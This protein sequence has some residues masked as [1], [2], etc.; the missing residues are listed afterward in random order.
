MSKNKLNRKRFL[1]PGAF[2]SAATA[3]LLTV[4]GCSLLPQEDQ[5]LKPPLVKPVEIQSRTAEATLGTIVKSLSGSAVL[6]PVTFA[7]HEFTE[8][9]GRIEEVLVRSG[10]EVK[11]GD[12]LIRLKTEGLDLE[13]IR[14]QVEVEKKRQEFDEAKR[15]R[16]PQALRVPA[17]ELKLAEEELK[18]VENQIDRLQLRAAMDGVVTFVDRIEPGDP[19]TA[20]RNAVTIADPHT[21]RLAFNSVPANRITEVQLGMEAM[22]TYKD[23]EF[24]GKVVQT[25]LSA[26]YTED[27]R[28]RELYSQTLY[29]EMDDP[30]EDMSMGNYVDVEILIAQRENVVI[31]P[32][33]GLRE[34]FGRVAV[35]VLDGESRREVDVEKGLETSTEVEIVK[36]LEAGQQIILK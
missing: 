23:Q 25:P 31:I 10:D 35:Q 21:M 4:S 29:I 9:G 26:P 17:L 20:F 11:E 1:R 18:V 5:P 34:Y 15:E 28:L 27:A 33:S 12:V 7:Y 24:G 3:V 32:K 2:A 14:K 13:L 16:D 8:A 30:P 19:V 36:G 22:L 6:E